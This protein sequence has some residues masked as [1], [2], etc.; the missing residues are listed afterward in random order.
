[1][2]P[3][4]PALVLAA[5]VLAGAPG[6]DGSAGSGPVRIAFVSDRGGTN[7]DLWVMN[8]DGSNQ[9]RVTNTPGYSEQESTCRP[10]ACA[11]RSRPTRRRTST[12]A[13]RSR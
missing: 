10:T 9:H 11:S 1:M 13:T 12:A 8:A 4:L 6:A 5:L 7:N 2:R 3:V